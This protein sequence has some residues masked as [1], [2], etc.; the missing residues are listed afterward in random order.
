MYIGNITLYWIFLL[1]QIIRDRLKRQACRD[2]EIWNSAPGALAVDMSYGDDL[3]DFPF[4]H[5]GNSSSLKV[6]FTAV[7]LI[8]TDTE[9][10]QKCIS[11]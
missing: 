10:W 11:I 6:N 7:I 4:F 3:D 9:C 5:V 2:S 8:Q 1:F